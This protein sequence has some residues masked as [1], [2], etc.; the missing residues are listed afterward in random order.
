MR[1]IAVCICSVVCVLVG[2]DSRADDLSQLGFGAAL[3][4]KW[5]RPAP[6]D[7][8][9]VGEA[10]IDPQGIV[11]VTKRVNTV[12]V[13]LPLL[14]HLLNIHARLMDNGAPRATH[15][16]VVRATLVQWRTPAAA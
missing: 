7:G 12:V 6:K 14:V 16:C 9:L 8:D 13:A 11:R 10:I 4:F 1:S 15:R 2:A 5:H 3:S